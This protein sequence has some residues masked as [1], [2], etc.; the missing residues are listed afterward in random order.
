[1]STSEITRDR[2]IATH[3]LIRQHIRRTPVVEA[4][5]ADFGLPPVQL[6]FKLEFLQHSG[7]FKTRGAFSNLLSRTIPPAGVV[8]ASGGNHGVAVAFAA[9]KLRKPATIFVPTVCSPEKMERIRGYGADL[10][11]TGER[12]ADALAASD[13][14][15]AE[16]GALR[17]HAYDQVETLL[18]QG[19]VG[20]EFEEQAPHLDALLVAVGGGGLIGGSSSNQAGP[21]RWPRYFPGVTSPS[22]ANVSAFSSAGATPVPSIFVSLP[23]IR[24]GI[25]ISVRS[26]E[27]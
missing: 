19:T 7:S 14:W 5:G 2:I 11:V 4:S 25:P 24:P 21:R 15:A 3:Q 10:V 12:Y 20:L 9:M 18:G 6:V 23:Q 8:A 16:W 17:I 13:A 1:M 22:P 26:S 27:P